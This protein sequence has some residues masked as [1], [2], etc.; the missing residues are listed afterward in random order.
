MQWSLRSDLFRYVLDKYKRN[1]SFS[2]RLQAA[3]SWHI[4]WLAN[5]PNLKQANQLSSSADYLRL[6]PVAGPGSCLEAAG[7]SRR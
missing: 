3:V 7:G 5:Q 4:P 2:F 6:S 1:Q